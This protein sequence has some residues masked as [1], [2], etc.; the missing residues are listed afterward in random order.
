MTDQRRDRKGKVF[1]TLKDGLPILWTLVPEMPQ[2]VVRSAL[3]WLVVISWKYDGSADNGMPKDD[4]NAEMLKFERALVTLEGPNSCFEA[5]RRIGNHLR[6]FVLYIADRDDF[7][8]AF[9]GRLAEHPHYP[10]DIKF[11]QDESWSEL[12]ELI[13]DLCP[14]SGIKVTH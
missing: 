13:D 8:A 4:V 3:N 7:M 2:E 14:S 11:Y 1:R 9:N 12:Q 5:Y 6:E 10:I